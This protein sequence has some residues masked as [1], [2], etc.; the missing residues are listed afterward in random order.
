MSQVRPGKWAFSQPEE[1]WSPD[2]G[3]VG[4]SQFGHDFPGEIGRRLPIRAS[5]AFAGAVS[6]LHFAGLGHGCTRLGH[7]IRHG[8]AA[9]M[10]G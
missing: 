6:C 10:A 7:H 1:A 8:R 5:L 4:S 3:K 9:A 2:E